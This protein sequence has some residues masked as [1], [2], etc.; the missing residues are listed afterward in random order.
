MRSLESLLLLLLSSMALQ[1]ELSGCFWQ[2]IVPVCD[3]RVISSVTNR[4][5]LKNDFEQK[6]LT[7]DLESRYKK[8][9]RIHLNHLARSRCESDVKVRF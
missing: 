2:V 8:I 9:A 4:N 6:N 1:Y 5:A 3:N 7:F